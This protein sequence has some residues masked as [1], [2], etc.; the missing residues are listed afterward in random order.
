MKDVFIIGF[1]LFSMFFGAGNLI[2]A[3]FLGA[4]TQDK[5]WIATGGFLITA[6]LGPYLGTLATIKAGG[7]VQDLTH[8]AGITVGNIISF[9]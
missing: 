5:W 4:L 7:Q 2:F 8:K 9:K 3:P 6:V 1:V